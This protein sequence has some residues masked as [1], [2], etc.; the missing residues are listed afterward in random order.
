[1]LFNLELSCGGTVSQPE[2]RWGVKVVTYFVNILFP[3]ERHGTKSFFKWKVVTNTDIIIMEILK[4]NP[5]LG[6]PT[7]CF[8]PLPS[9][10]S[11]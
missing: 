10:L 7:F 6:I 3:E 4:F 9:F 8:L 5:R 1:M 2:Q 11:P